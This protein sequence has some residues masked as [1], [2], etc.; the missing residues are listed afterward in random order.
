MF[1]TSQPSVGGVQA[2]A[3][4]LCEKAL[5]PMRNDQKAARDS[6]NYSGGEPELLISLARSHL[7]LVGAE[8]EVIIESTE[9]KQLQVS[10]WNE[11]GSLF[12]P[13]DDLR[14]KCKY[15]SLL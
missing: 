6:W 4:D 2:K 11:L 14:P 1:G 15:P 3:I 13:L 12:N 10:F 9:W 8:I 5:A 7:R